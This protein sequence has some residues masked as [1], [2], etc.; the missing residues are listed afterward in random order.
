[1]KFS[2]FG[3]TLL[4]DSEVRKIFR[5]EL[6]EY[7][8]TFNESNENHNKS[9]VKLLESINKKIDSNVNTNR[10]YEENPTV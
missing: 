9:M 6:R 4:T 1:M 2:L 8:T 10:T 3:I 5:Q 7:L